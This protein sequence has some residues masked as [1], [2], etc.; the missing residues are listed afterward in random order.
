MMRVCRDLQ[1]RA[2]PTR[3]PRASASPALYAKAVRFRAL[4]AGVGPPAHRRR[5]QA[6]HW[7]A[8]AADPS[9][10][11]DHHRSESRWLRGIRDEETAP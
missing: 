3:P 5:Q 1:S 8:C 11:D 10:R 9:Q 7:G 6:W 2:I 4:H